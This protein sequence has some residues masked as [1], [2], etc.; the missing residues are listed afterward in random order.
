MD[1][2]QDE[3]NKTIEFDKD[4]DV[5]WDVLADK[6][7]NEKAFIEF[8]GVIH[9]YVIRKFS[10]DSIVLKLTLVLLVTFL[11]HLNYMRFGHHG[12]WCFIANIRLVEQ[13]QFPLEDKWLEIN[14][15]ILNFDGLSLF[16]FLVSFFVFGNQLVKSIH[17]L[18]VS[19]EAVVIVIHVVDAGHWLVRV[20][21]FVLA[22]NS[23]VCGTWVHICKEASQIVSEILAEKLLCVHH[24]DV[25]IWSVES[26]VLNVVHNEFDGQ[27]DTVVDGMTQHIIKVEVKSRAKH[28]LIQNEATLIKDL[29]P[30]SG[31]V[32]ADDQFETRR[33]SFFFLLDIFEYKV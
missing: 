6:D 8:A 25:I 26:L 21:P 18:V 31:L 29:V 7:E 12:Y 3:I 28:V 16:A 22:V 23:Y 2:W 10:D 13:I 1:T 5:E 30:S 14:L 33:L 9:E 20:Q 4:L 19:L 32:W 15:W 27:F 11:E 17:D 24:D